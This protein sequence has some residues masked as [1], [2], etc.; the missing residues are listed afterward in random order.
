MSHSSRIRDITEGGQSPPPRRAKAAAASV[1]TAVVVADKA[2]DAVASEASASEY[3]LDDEALGTAATDRARRA[4]EEE[5]EKERA[6]LRNKRSALA[7]LQPLVSPVVA[8]AEALVDD[9]GVEDSD[10]EAEGE[11][12]QLAPGAGRYRKV[13]KTPRSAKKKTSVMHVMFTPTGT[14]SVFNCRLHEFSGK[15]H[16][17]GVKAKSGTSNLLLHARNYHKDVYEALIKAHNDGDD[18]EQVFD[19][20]L[21]SL[22]V[23]GHKDGTLD[24][25]GFSVVKKSELM[26]SRQLA[27]LVCI[28]ANCLAFSL[29][30]S[31]HFVKWMSLLGAAYPSRR[32][33]MKLLPVLY[34][35]AIRS[36][37]SELKEA[38]CMSLTFDAW[39]SLSGTKYLVVTVHAITPDWKMLSAP[40]DL[41]PMHYRAYG[42]LMAVAILS[43][44]HDHKLDDVLLVSSTSD[45]ASNCKLT[46]SLLTPGDEEPCFNHCMHLMIN[47]VIDGSD[48]KAPLDPTAAKDFAALAVAITFIRGSSTL[49]AELKAECKAQKC[50]RL[51]LVM[52]N[53]TRWEGRHDA[54]YRVLQLRLA[55]MR[56]RSKGS[57]QSMLEKSSAALSQDVFEAAYFDRLTA[58]L[59]LLQLLVTISKAA[60]SQAGPTLS[61]VPHFLYKLRSACMVQQNDGR[62]TKHF[63]KAMAL[64]ISSRL[65]VFVEVKVNDDERI[66]SN[67]IKAALLDPRHSAEVQA[68]LSPDE[69]ET[70]R[71]AIIDDV[72]H[73]LPPMRAAAYTSTMEA[74]WPTL[75]EELK[76]APAGL[77]GPG[78]LTWWASF[79]NTD[80]GGLHVN[81]AR[82]ARMLLAIPAGSS[83][84]ESAFSSTGEAVTKKRTRLSDE[85]LEMLTITRHHIRGATFDLTDMVTAVIGD[86]KEAIARKDESSSES[87][88]E[89]E[90][91]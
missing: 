30:D 22:S 47:D 59:P 49:R 11:R 14:A 78:V 53:V 9:D 6:R 89:E 67:A 62:V 52:E 56:M 87:D 39:T 74:A 10:D 80:A 23:P 40:I 24:T 73:L 82:G 20:V 35:R 15:A 1:V 21:A 91:L 32:T 19:G 77:D 76:A 16:P 2:Q 72:L 33:L 41:I 8:A 60:Q 48:T 70:S 46:K 90:Q 54:V 12:E 71:D 50:S 66:V 28:I 4:A 88:E 43:R 84:S 36:L 26:L 55:L 3:D 85:T 58:Y 29:V 25:L 64:A 7:D 31:P 18:V 45:G 75:L 63:K 61:R 79:A 5:Q 17:L 86:A 83:P 57:L 34:H 68:K 38:G 44:I 51:E 42:E 27:L 65:D 37:V 69:L 13:P 81:W